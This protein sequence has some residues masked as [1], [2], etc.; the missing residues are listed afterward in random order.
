M[1]FGLINHLSGTPIIIVPTRKIQNRKHKKKRINKKW[2]KK[3]G[4]RL[5]FIEG[6][7][8]DTTYNTKTGEF[9]FSYDDET[10]WQIYKHAADI[11]VYRV[12]SEIGY[13]DWK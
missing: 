6:K 12:L 1:D 9:D 8:R 7:T 3:Y 13:T 11:F 10:I 2:A 4:Y 5:K